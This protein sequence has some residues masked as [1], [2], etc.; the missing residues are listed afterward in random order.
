MPWVG[1]SM[2][3]GGKVRPCSCGAL[4]AVAPGE[5]MYGQRGWRITATCGTTAFGGQKPSL[6]AAW[7]AYLNGCTSG[8]ATAAPVS[9][10]VTGEK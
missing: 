7:N 6:V 1:E 5:G 9:P 10:P 4:A 3:R 2:D 8:P